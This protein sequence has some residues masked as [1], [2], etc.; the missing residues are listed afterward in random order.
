MKSKLAK[1]NL[2]CGF[3]KKSFIR[4]LL[5]VCVAF[6]ISYNIY[7][8]NP[9]IWLLLIGGT[10]GLFIFKNHE[11]G[12]IL[13]FIS[14]FLLDWMSDVIGIIPRHI[15]WL[16]E[17]ILIILFFKLLFLIATE[18]KS[19]NAI[20]TTPV[21]FLIILGITSAFVN[22]SELMVTFAGFRN[23]FKFIL[24]FYVI[25]FLHF[26]NVFLKKVVIFLIVMAFI[27]IPVTILQRFWY[28]GRPT[29]DP[30]GGTLGANTS[31][32]LTLFLLGII[33]ILVALFMNKLIKGRALL[34]LLILLFIPMAINETKITFYLFPVLVLFILRKNLL[35]KQSA[36]P[37]FALIIFS[38]VIFIGSYFL[39]NYIFNEIY[40]R[41]I[42]PFDYN[43]T[44]RYLTTKYIDSGSLNRLAQVK[45][46]NRNINK[47]IYTAFLGVG[48]GNASDS[49]F[50]KGVG[51]YFRKYPTLKIDSVFLGRFI[52]EYGYLGLIIFLYILFRLFCLAE[53]IYNNSSD[54]FYKSLALG[55]EGMMLILVVTTVYSSSFIIDSIGYIFWF[56][57]AYLQRIYKELAIVKREK[58]KV[59]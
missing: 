29:G 39:Y 31:G 42:K 25:S 22:S 28:I 46:A 7:Y 37:I 34:F 52:W 35:K 13:I 57:A 15:T 54:P 30:I 47:D 40:Q 26:D 36:K 14:L 38:G 41:N 2:E 43:Y 18:K 49:F 45:F 53:K 8:P 21:L 44:A 32:T 11:S 1:Y 56:M 24:F 48:P 50:E 59:F 27:Q 12:V 20:I 19:L 4:S 16:P 55:F 6:F 23:Y 51:Y 17:I 9:Y 58:I 33:S 10:I 5:I 3:P